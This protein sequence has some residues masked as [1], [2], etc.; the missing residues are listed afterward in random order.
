MTSKGEGERGGERDGQRGEGERSTLWT[1]L[2]GPPDIFLIQDMTLFMYFRAYG[3]VLNGL[4]L[5]SLL[6]ARFVQTASRGTFGG[7]VFIGGLWDL[8]RGVDGPLESPLSRCEQAVD[9]AGAL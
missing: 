2:D 3:L 1:L 8:E 7:V 9:E 5:S 6:V 4:L